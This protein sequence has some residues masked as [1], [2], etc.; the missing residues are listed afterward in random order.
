MGALYRVA[1][2]LAAV[3]IV[4][5]G[6]SMAR[7]D[8]AAMRDVSR[9]PDGEGVGQAPSSPDDLYARRED[10]AAARAAA[11]AWATRLAASPADFESA[12]KLARVCY[13]LGTHGPDARRRADLERGITAADTAIRL[14]P[15]APEGYFWRGAN[16]GA[17][18]E[19]F[20][21]SQGV[22]YRKPIRE[23][24][25]KVIALDPAFQQGSAGRALGRWYF[26]VPGLFG[27]SNA[28]SVEHLLQSLQYDPQST[29]SLYFLAETY[30]DMGKKAEARDVLRRLAAASI[31]RDWAPEDREWKAK[32]EALAAKVL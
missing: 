14:R 5:T 32:G 11:D 28:K 30:I 13:W 20:G 1:V 29:A 27:G 19:S 21:I 23:A 8:A 12:W 4:S 15:G 7:I 10:P 24:L 31:S 9:Q 6:V 2:G 18:A 3:W 22:K 25:E 17:L 26:K 16:M